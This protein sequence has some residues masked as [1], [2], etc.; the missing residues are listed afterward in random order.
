MARRILIT[1][2][3]G[4]GKTTLA[5]LAA[6]FLPSPRLLVD[7]D[8]D[9]HLA[10]V[11]GVDLHAS[12]VR[13]ISEA[14]FE[15]Q[16]RKGPRDLDAMPLP[17]RVEYVLHLSCLYE[18]ADFDLV[19]LGVKWTRGCYCAPNEILR[20][21]LPRIAQSYA[22]T[23][24][25]SPA[26]IEHVNRRAFHEVDD[27]FAVMDPSSKSLR[28]TEILRDMA[29]QIGFHYENLFI[30]ANHRF[31]GA[32]EA[33]LRTVPGTTFIGRIESDPAVERCEWEDTS[34]LALPDDSPAC[35]S[36]RDILGRAGYPVR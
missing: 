11:L 12:G 14:L 20:T 29:P 27:V 26:G 15:L 24:I 18:C 31:A 25:D 8:P 4:T 9:Q 32:D 30:V 23:I 33:R 21:L 3:G 13:T 17:D 22:F 5:A 10:A 6:R 19:S 35:V 7:A 2:R 1:G 28:N 36:I 34:L 16:G